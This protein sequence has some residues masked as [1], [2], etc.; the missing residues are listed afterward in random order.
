MSDGVSI[1][2]NELEDTIFHG[3][4]FSINEDSG[5]D[6]SINLSSLSEREGI[7]TIIHGITAVGMGEEN[8]RSLFGP[9][10][11][12]YN[13]D[14]RALIYMFSVKS[15]I[16][17]KGKVCS[18]FLIFRKDLIRFIANVYSMIESMLNVYQDN[19]LVNESDLQD[20]TIEKIYEDLIANLKYKPRIRMFRIN[21]GITVEFEERNIMFGN[22][23]TALIDEKDKTIYVYIPRNITKEL[24]IRTKK[25]VLDINSLEYQSLYK[26]VQLPSKAKFTEI[27]AEKNI[28]IID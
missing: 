9:I 21:N 28:I 18:L 11:V 13:T 3:M 2:T 26:I 23:L 8:H 22:E 15:E 24:K 20:E 1:S 10:P 7:A 14:F 27:L 5:P 4:L 6:L 25:L 16:S 19:Y 12:P 17:A